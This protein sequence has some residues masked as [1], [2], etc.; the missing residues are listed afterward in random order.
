[1]IAD[2]AGGSGLAIWSE[3]CMA[4]KAMTVECTVAAISTGRR[5]DL[6]SYGV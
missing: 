2:C 3:G 6:R 5:H 1:V 4:A